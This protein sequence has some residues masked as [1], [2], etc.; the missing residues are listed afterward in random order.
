MKNG[1]F[2]VDTRGR[3]FSVETVSIDVF[4]VLNAASFNLVSTSPVR[5]SDTKLQ[6]LLQFLIMIIIIQYSTNTYN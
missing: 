6:I 5:A 3:S 2:S 1:W 4:S